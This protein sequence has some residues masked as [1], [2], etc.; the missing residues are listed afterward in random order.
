MNWRV[1]VVDDEPEFLELM[2]Y[3]LGRAGFD[4]LSAT[5]GLDAI[6]LTRRRQPDIV[7][8]D[9]RMPGLDGISVCQVLN[10]N[11]ETARIPIIMVS[12][13]DNAATREAGASAGAM[14]HLTKPVDFKTLADALNAAIHDRQMFFGKMR[15]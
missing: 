8:L 12:A 1:L 2:T 10:R 9:I 6:I 3:N 14:R 15:V 5:N 11:P 13:L 4:V 7:L